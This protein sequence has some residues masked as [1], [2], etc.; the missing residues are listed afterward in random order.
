MVETPV[1]VMMV[2][3]DEDDFVIVRDLLRDIGAGRY[4]LTWVADYDHALRQA[5]STDVDVVLA[6]YHLGSRSGIE[7]VRDLLARNC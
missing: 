2:D 4:G 3:D 6:D 1:K 5:C 7:L